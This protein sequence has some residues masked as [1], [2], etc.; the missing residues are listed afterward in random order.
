MDKNQC[1]TITCIE[2]F[3]DP[4]KAPVKVVEQIRLL[5]EHQPYAPSPYQVEE[6]FSFTSST[7]KKLCV[8]DSPKSAAER[9][10]TQGAALWNIVQVQAELEYLVVHPEARGLGI[11]R[12]LMLLSQRSLADAGATE[13]LLEVSPTNT[14][15]IKLYQSLGYS[16]IGKRDR[17]YSNGEDA[18]VMR[19][20]IS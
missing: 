11:A 7:S 16:V 4:C 18:A 20:V 10:Q 13:L 12:Q 14:P 3:T 1:S 2:I 9:P 15:A 8:T 5:C 17:Y 19:L 6:F